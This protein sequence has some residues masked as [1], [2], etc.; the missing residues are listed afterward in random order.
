MRPRILIVDD[1]PFNVDYLEQELDDLGYDTVSAGDGAAALEA[2]RGEKPDLVLLDIM[3][4]VMDGF[5]VLERLKADPSTRDIPVVVISAMSDLA[6]IV[7]GITLGAD[8]YLPK[9]FEPVLLHARIGAGLERK[10]RRDREIEYL[11]AVERLTGAAKS[12]QDAT[13]DEATIAPVA[14]RDDALGNLA[15]MFGGMVREVAAREQRLKQQ[16]RQLQHDLD[17]RNAAAAESAA[18]WVP[19][20]R[21]IALIEGRELSGNVEGCALIADVAGF[22]VLAEAFAQALGALR[23]AEELTRQVNRA[24][25]LVTDE[26]HRYRGSVIGFGGDAITCWFD[27]D[28]A[29]RAVACA[30][31]MQRTLRAL[32]AVTAPGGVE[33]SLGVKV[34][35]ALGRGTRVLAGDPALQVVEALAGAAMHDLGVAA[36][37][38][39]RGE[40]VVNRRLAS[41]L[42][43]A[44]AV[45]EWRGEGDAACVTVAALRVSADPSP[46]PAL[47]AEALDDERARPWLAP[48]VYARVHARQSATLAELRPAAT[49]FLRFGGLDYERD[50]DAGAKLDNFV[51]WVQSVTARFEGTLLQLVHDDKGAYFHIVFGVPVSHRDDALRA[52]RAALALQ[53]PPPEHAGIGNVAAGL[54]W[55]ALRTGAYG[56]AAQRAYTAFGDRANLA[57]RLMMAADPGTTLCGEAIHAAAREEI[58]FEAL[59]PIRVKGFAEPVRIYRPRGEAVLDAAAAARTLDLL[60]PIDQALVKTASAI[61][62]E[63]TLGVLAAVHPQGAAGAGVASHLDALVAQRLVERVPEV[64][65]DKAAGRRERIPLDEGEASRS[66]RYRFAQPALRDA[67]YARMP[68]AQRRQLHRDIAQWYERECADLS[69]YHAT[70]AMHWRAAEE[71]A[72][73]AECFERAAEAARA[74]GALEEAARYLGESLA[75]ERG[76]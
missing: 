62:R 36:A 35:V 56:S 76:P 55:G 15:R 30:F 46:W 8:D 14:A 40:V 10:L 19:M 52:V 68:F 49:L 75:L 12:V 64:D 26:V 32:E 63:F 20:D 16:L 44:I 51:R 57:A 1:E 73:A 38:A 13:Y 71:P 54:G 65:G 48:A 21:R 74:R 70:L 22:T 66:A 59:A 17:E 28:A 61:G 18:A 39:R 5:A 24:L 27:G 47:A 41:A 33:V 31:A 67:A 25:A 69:P 53:R 6:S 9:P 58:D 3:M 45:G 43:E 2:V 11:Q 72:R 42:G 60:D 29:R 4:P 50:C 7:R 23:G 34:A 37:V